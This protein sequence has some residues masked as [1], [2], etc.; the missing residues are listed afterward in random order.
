ME[1]NKNLKFLLSRLKECGTAVYLQTNDGKDTPIGFITEIGD[2]Y[3]IFTPEE[4]DKTE[5]IIIPIPSISSVSIKQGQI[6][7]Y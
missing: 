3:I 4:T 5:S 7:H 2:D 1:K 6:I